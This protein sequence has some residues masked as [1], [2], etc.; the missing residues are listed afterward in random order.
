MASLTRWTWVWASSGRWGRTGKPGVLQSMR[1]QTVR[2]AWTTEQHNMDNGAFFLSSCLWK[3]CT[4]LIRKKHLKLW[5][6]EIQPLWQSFLA[7]K[8]WKCL[9]SV[10]LLWTV[11]CHSVEFSGQKCW[12]G[13]PFP[14]LEDFHNPRIKPGSPA[15]QADSLPPEP[16]GKC[17]F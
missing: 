9:S 17:A 15:L 10:W 1:L 12:S 16:L 8:C 5:Y 11:T 7:E 14:S 3:Y 13:W 6:Q 4:I 2:Y